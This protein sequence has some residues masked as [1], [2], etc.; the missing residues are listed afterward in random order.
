MGRRRIREKDVRMRIKRR[1]DKERSCGRGE[2]RRR[3][4]MILSGTSLPVII[5]VMSSH[6]T[7]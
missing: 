2:G 4:F 1:K 7:H 3:K 6:S 5:S